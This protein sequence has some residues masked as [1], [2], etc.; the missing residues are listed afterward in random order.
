MRPLDA[1]AFASLSIFQGFSKLLRDEPEFTADV[2]V[3]DFCVRSGV[4]RIA[5]QVIQA[6]VHHP[7]MFCRVKDV[8]VD[9]ATQSRLA[10]VGLYR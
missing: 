3:W 9:G 5:A 7:P 2:C 6:V 8:Y 1:S 10:A 4:F